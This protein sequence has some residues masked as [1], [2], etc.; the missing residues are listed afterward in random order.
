MKFENNWKNQEIVKGLTLG[1]LCVSR[2]YDGAMDDNY[3]W[4]LAHEDVRENLSIVASSLEIL[5]FRL[6]PDNQIQITSCLR[7]P[8]C[9]EK[10]GGAKKSLHM[11]GLAVDM[12]APHIGDVWYILTEECPYLFEYVY[13]YRQRKFIHAAIHIGLPPLPDM[14]QFIIKG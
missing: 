2:A 13:W 14:R 12:V 5:K 9:N 11:Q 7:C 10:V 1:E 3:L 8:K 4:W 6:P